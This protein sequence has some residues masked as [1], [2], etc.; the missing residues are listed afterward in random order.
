MKNIR[1]DFGVLIKGNP[2]IDNALHRIIDDNPLEFF[3]VMRP[4]CEA[5]WATAAL[6]MMNVVFTQIPLHKLFKD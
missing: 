5:L 1:F 3:E 2:Q 4:S 6:K